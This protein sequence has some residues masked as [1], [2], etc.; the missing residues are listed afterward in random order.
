MIDS[1]TSSS[2][3]P[4]RGLRVLVTGAA[5][6]IG[7]ALVPRLLDA[8]ATVVGI[9]VRQGHTGPGYEHVQGDAA[10]LTAD[11]L[12]SLRPDMVVH[13]ASVVGVVAASADPEATRSTILGMTSRFVDLVE[14]L[15][16]VRFVYVSSSEV[17]GQS[18]SFPLVETSPLSPLSA[19]GCAKREAEELVVA[20][21]E[22]GRLD[23]VVVRPF[24]VYGPGQRTD[25]VVT[26]FV[27]Q[28][29]RG[30]EVTVVGSGD[31]LRTFTYVDDF[32]D[33]LLR[34]AVHQG[35]ERL[36]NLSGHETW[37]IGAL[38][39][40]VVDLADS[41]SPVVS[42]APTDL[43]RPREIEVE[44]RVAS[45]DR[46]RRVLGYHPRVGVLEGVARCVAAARAV[47]RD[48]RAEALVAG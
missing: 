21:T 48:D 19:Y 9:D 23:G 43:G 35:D 17:Y 41:S 39:S 20:E 42:T 29:L 40:T 16:G 2:A 13:L 25:F 36:F 11:Q 33:G 37:T 24:N 34:A 26:R 10:A 30:D 28:A 15:G 6:F 4:Y 12:S 38:A 27:E 31:Q 46:A 3:S 1:F 22:A 5:G 47:E 18:A 7:S 44:N 8:G 32:V 45:C 14:G